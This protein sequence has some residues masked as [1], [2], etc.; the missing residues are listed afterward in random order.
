MPQPL[1]LSTWKFGQRSNAAGWPTLARGGSS[2]DAVEAVGRF[3]EEDPTNATVGYGG[4]PDASGRVSLDASVMLSPAKRGAVANVR[5]FVHAVSIARRVM[6]KTPHVLLAGEQADE[7]AL[8]QGFHPQELLTEESRQEWMQW[9]Q[10]QRDGNAAGRPVRN[11]EERGGAP[12]P[13]HDTIGVLA[14]DAS[15]TLAG[16]CTTS[17]MAYKVPGRVGDS[18]IIGHALYVDPNVGAAVATGHGELV[19]GVCGAFLAVESMRRGADPKSAAV[20]LIRRIRDSYALGDEDQVGV[21]VL[22][23]DGTWSAGALTSGFSV[24][25]RLPDRDGLVEVDPS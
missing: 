2:L 8:E 10:Q 18:P 21:I 15:G 23:R 1:L 9:K 6:E 20:E 12:Q 3:A 22:R 17:G 14:I 16:C 24:A 5:R 19:M 25:V 13:N 11:I 7:F 4:R